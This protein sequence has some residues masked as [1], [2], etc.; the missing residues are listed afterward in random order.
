MQLIVFLVV[1][2]SSVLIHDAAI[3]HLNGAKK[4]RKV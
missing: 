4:S 3:A 2:G 1:F